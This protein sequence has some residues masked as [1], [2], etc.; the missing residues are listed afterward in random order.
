ME[1]LLVIKR[2]SSLSGRVCVGVIS[3]VEIFSIWEDD[4][5]LD[6]TTLYISKLSILR[7]WHPCRGPGSHLPQ[8]S[9]DYCT[10]IH[11]R[12]NFDLSRKNKHPLYSFIH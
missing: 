12:L 7:F 3:N 1:V 11:L 6:Q 5:R 10:C 4:C 8:I 2:Y 9:M